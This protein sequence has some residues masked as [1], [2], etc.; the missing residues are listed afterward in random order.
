MGNQLPNR[1]S[2]ELDQESIRARAHQLWVERGCVEGDDQRDWFE[3]ERQL[4]DGAQ[5]AAEQSGVEAASGT[6][7]SGELAAAEDAT[8][9]RTRSSSPAPRV[10][11]PKPKNSNS[12][13]RSKK[14]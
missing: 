3:A 11:S 5:P 12:K 6:T 10:S 7:P 1:A 2:G 13:P 9:T 8:G 14:R 4:R